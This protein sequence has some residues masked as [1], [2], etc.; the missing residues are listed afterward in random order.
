MRLRNKDSGAL[1]LLLEKNVVSRFLD[2]N[3]G[4]YMGYDRKDTADNALVLRNHGIGFGDPVVVTEKLLDDYESALEG[5]LAA[6]KKI[7]K[8]INNK[9]VG[10]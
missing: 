7:R 10:V 9:E 5:A 2:I 1:K 8:M 4:Y 6:V 3:K